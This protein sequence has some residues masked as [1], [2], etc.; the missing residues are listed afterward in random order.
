MVGVL[1]LPWN[2]IWWVIWTWTYS[3]QWHRIAFCFPEGWRVQF[4]LLMRRENGKGEEKWCSEALE[5]W[6]YRLSCHWGSLGW[7][8]AHLRAPGGA[9]APAYCLLRAVAL[10][11]ELWG[12]PYFVMV[13]IVCSEL[14]WFS[15]EG[16]FSGC[17]TAL[18][19]PDPEQLGE[20]SLRNSTAVST[21]S[22]KHLI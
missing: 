14:L 20:L 16:L 17:V 10:P 8:F 7:Y 18:L 22:N 4:S 2:P 1:F 9:A 6:F 5:T 19:F 13:S 21:S 12:W 11:R 3:W 15:D